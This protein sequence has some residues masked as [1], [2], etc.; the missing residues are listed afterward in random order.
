[1]VEPT[2]PKLSTEDIELRH[3]QRSFEDEFFPLAGIAVPDL[4]DLI[5]DL[6]VGPEVVEN[7][8]FYG[9]AREIRGDFVHCERVIA[10]EKVEDR[11]I[12]DEFLA[13][14]KKSFLEQ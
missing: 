11:A 14:M 6:F 10:V 7:G 2:S 5:L 4:E 13:L 12:D 3:F 9:L 8:I 1:M